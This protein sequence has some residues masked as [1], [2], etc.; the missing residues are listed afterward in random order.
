LPFALFASFAFWRYYVTC[1]KLPRPWLEPLLED[2]ADH[3][4]SAWH[5]IRPPRPQAGA[6]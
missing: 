6:Q 2:I 5:R 4:R 1:Y 3:A